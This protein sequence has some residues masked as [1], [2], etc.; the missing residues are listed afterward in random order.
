MEKKKKATEP[1][2]VDSVDALIAK[3]EQV[4]EAQRIFSTYTQEQVDKIFLAAA[5]AANQAAYS[6]GENGRGR[7]R[8]GRCGGQGHQEPLCGRVYLQR[9]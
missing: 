9:I 6:A 1:M 5:T 8:H 4:R 3:M 7:N 2:I